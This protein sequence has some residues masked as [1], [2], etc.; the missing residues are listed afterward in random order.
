VR[1][2]AGSGGTAEVERA[3]TLL[4]RGVIDQTE[5]EQLKQKALA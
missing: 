3:K 2:T 5:F 4:D 1:E